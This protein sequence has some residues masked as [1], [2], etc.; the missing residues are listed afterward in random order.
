MKLEVIEVLTRLNVE[1]EYS[2]NQV[3]FK[4]KGSYVYEQDLT[5]ILTHIRE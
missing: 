1:V 3:R 4:I 2:G 5:K